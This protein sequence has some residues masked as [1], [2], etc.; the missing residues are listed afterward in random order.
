MVSLRNLTLDL[1][2]STE[3]LPANTWSDY[4]VMWLICH[5]YKLALVAKNS[6]SIFVKWKLGMFQ[7]MQ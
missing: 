3:N 2:Q 7:T 6:V 4:Q 5:D 1:W